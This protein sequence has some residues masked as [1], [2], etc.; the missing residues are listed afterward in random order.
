[1]NTK[2]E[3]KHTEGPWSIG[4]ETDFIQD[5]L[6]VPINADS[7]GTLEIGLVNTADDQDQGTANARLIAAAPDL[8]EAAKG[9]LDSWDN[10]GGDVDA[11]D[12]YAVRQAID[13]ALAEGRS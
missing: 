3:A 11:V 1:M 2:T 5:C 7:I 6:Y 10:H 4:A 8:L 12:I 13:K 9:V